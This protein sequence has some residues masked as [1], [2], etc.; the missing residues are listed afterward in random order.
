MLELSLMI[1][2]W[3]PL[4]QTYFSMRRTDRTEWV[5]LDTMAMVIARAYKVSDHVFGPRLFSIRAL[6]VSAF[7]SIFYFI[8]SLGVAYLSSGPEVR[9]A[10]VS[11]VSFNFS[12]ASWFMALALALA[13]VVDFLSVAQT[14]FLVKQIKVTSPPTYVFFVLAIDALISVAFSIVMVF[15]L[16]LCSGAVRCFTGQLCNGYTTLELPLAQARDSLLAIFQTVEGGFKDFIIFIVTESYNPVAFTETGSELVKKA[17][18]LHRVGSLE[19]LHI[20]PF[21]TFISSTLLTSFWLWTYVVAI[22]CA[23]LLLIEERMAKRIGAIQVP[24][25]VVIYLGVLISFA[26]YLFA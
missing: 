7:F 25:R 1:A 14:R 18:H 20:F 5:S 23:R 10:I 12:Y 11:M 8:I 15:L 4:I 17:I 26:I 22:F 16:Y 9:S 19:V 2:L 24:S 3:I 13:I 6:S 21:T